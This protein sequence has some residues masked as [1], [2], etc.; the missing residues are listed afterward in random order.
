[1]KQNFQ[2]LMD[3]ELK[4]IESTGEKPVLLLQ[5]CCA[6]CSSAVLERLQEHFRLKLYFYNPNIYPQEEYEKRL[7]QFDKLL[8][9]EEFSK[10]IEILPSVYEPEEFEKAVKGLENEKEGGARCTECFILRLEETAKKAKEIGADYFCTTLTVSPHKNSQLL[11][12]LGV[13]AGEKYG[14]KFLP[15]DFKKQEGYKRSTVLSNELGLYRQN[16]CG[17]RYSI[18]F[19]K[20]NEVK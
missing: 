16:Y 6:P 13:K 10:G 1:M 14:V 2:L 15:S 19:E 9:A 17:C 20:E 8:G 7:A 12:E 3:E 18:W 11:N 4:K 5:C